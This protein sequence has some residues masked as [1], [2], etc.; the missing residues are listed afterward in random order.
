[1]AFLP[2]SNLFV[3]SRSA[4]LDQ[5]LFGDGHEMQ[6]LQSIKKSIDAKEFSFYEVFEKVHSG[7][8]PNIPRSRVIIILSITGRL[9]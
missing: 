7:L 3:V 2:K 9:A 4:K 5:V 6:I 8:G 1:M